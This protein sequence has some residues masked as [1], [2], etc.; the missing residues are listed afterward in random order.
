MKNIRV[1]VTG[2]TGCLGRPLGEKLF[3]DGAYLKLLTLPNDTSKSEL[4]KKVEIVIGNL[5]SLE[6]LDLLTKDCDVVFHLA[7]K[8]HSAPGTKEEEQEFYRVNVEG[9]RNLLEA[10]KKN[11]VKRVVF[12]STVGVYGKDADFH[13]D[14]FS[15]CQPLSVYAKSKYLAE[16]LVLNSPNHGGPEGSV[17][18]FPVVYGSLDRGNVAKLIKAVKRKQFFFFGEGNCLR[19]MISSKNAAEA[20]V[21]AA[22]EPKASNQVFCVTDG[23]DYTMNELADCICGALGMSWRPFH[24]PVLL[25]DLAGKFGDILRKWGHVPF[26]I[27]SDR[28]RKLS[29]PLTFSSEKA[30]KVLGYAPVETLEEGIKKEV[31]WLYSQTDKK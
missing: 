22:I 24:V 29:R 17:L 27:D 25:A 3:A 5:N 13:G 21:K 20:A 12:Y 28:V 18:R 23:R 16:Q 2:G 26:P 10:A 30:K 7:G 19:S 15:P 6:A 14:E 9:T 11:G 4:G 1:A 31:E 8:V